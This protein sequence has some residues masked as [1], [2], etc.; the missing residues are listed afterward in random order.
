MTCFLQKQIMCSSLREKET[1]R[2]WPVSAGWLAREKAGMSRSLHMS[3]PV[4]AKLPQRRQMSACCCQ[5]P[6]C[7]TLAFWQIIDKLRW[8]WLAAHESRKLGEHTHR[9]RDRT[10][11]LP[12]AKLRGILRKKSV[13]ALSG[14]VGQSQVCEY[15]AVAATCQREM[16]INAD[17]GNFRQ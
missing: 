11:P 3:C 12:S 4:N 1:L 5:K 13:L 15:T 2:S 8:P 16:P 14:R 6:K 17:A 9:P 10:S 7:I